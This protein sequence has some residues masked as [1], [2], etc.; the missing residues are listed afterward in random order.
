[1]QCPPSINNGIGRPPIDAQY[2]SL[3]ASKIAPFCAT[4]AN[5]VAAGPTGPTGPTGPAGN[6]SLSTETVTLVASP[7]G[8]ALSTD[9]STTI[10]NSDVTPILNFQK[11]I[12]FKTDSF[13]NTS[14]F[15]TGV[16]DIKKNT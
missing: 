16:T 4:R 11:A 13:I 5:H 7:T 15:V 12:Q 1:M 9:I 6:G 10:V 8:T 3:W 14:D 2:T